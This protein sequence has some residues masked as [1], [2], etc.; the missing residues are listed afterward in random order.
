MSEEKWYEHSLN[1]SITSVRQLL[2]IGWGMCSISL[3]SL[4]WSCGKENFLSVS[5]ICIFWQLG[6]SWGEHYKQGNDHFLL[7]SPFFLK[8]NFYWNIVD[9]QSCVYSKVNQLYICIYPFLFRFFSH[10]GYYT[11]LQIYSYL[12]PSAFC[13]FVFVF[14]FY[15][16]QQRKFW[17]FMSSQLLT[18]IA[19]ESALLWQIKIICV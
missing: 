14:H 7:I 5:N 3:L 11:V 18:E 8:K 13:L 17:S 4:K 6:D 12:Q 2:V 19:E 1:C 10:I 15:F 9:L 16:C